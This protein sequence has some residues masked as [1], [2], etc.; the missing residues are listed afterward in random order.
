MNGNSLK[1][2]VGR[3]L[4]FIGKDEV[5][6]QNKILIGSDL[7]E[8]ETILSR[9]RLRIEVKDWLIVVDKPYLELDDSEITGL[10]ERVAT[11]INVKLR[12]IGFRVTVKKD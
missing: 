11:A 12:F 9:D 4:D 8:V 3:F 7:K 5:K 2:D 6:I 10:Y 1:L